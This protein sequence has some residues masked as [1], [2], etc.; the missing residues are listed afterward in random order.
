MVASPAPITASPD[1]ARDG[2]MSKENTTGDFPDA[3]P[4]GVEVVLRALRNLD[5]PPE[6]DDEI[7]RDPGLLA[8][9]LFD[10]GHRFDGMHML[11]C[12]TALLIPDLDD[13]A[14]ELCAQE[15]L[16]LDTA[17]MS[18]EAVVRLYAS[19]LD[20]TRKRPFGA[21]A[22]RVM[23]DVAR[24]ATAKGDML[25]D[26]IDVVDPLK[27][28]LL[29]TA[30]NEANKL[31][32][33]ARRLAW[34]AWVDQLSIADIAEIT[35]V[36]FERVEWVLAMVLERAQRAIKGVSEELGLT[37]KDAWQEFL[38]ELDDLEDGEEESHG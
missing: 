14:M 27:K 19:L 8:E 20:G 24:M 26:P 5:D 37:N 32:T 36:P 16:L 30:A 2:W 15:Y 13:I 4:D 7:A 9:V 6:I 12:M 3:E 1:R 10:H 31:D 34:L 28:R 35:G 38:D 23:R 22:R 29:L 21:W 33:D 25:P 11:Y 17:Q 18:E